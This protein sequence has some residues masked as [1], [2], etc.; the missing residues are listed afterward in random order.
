MIDFGGQ[1]R[2]RYDCRG[3]YCRHA[4]RDSDQVGEAVTLFA[5]LHGG[6]HRGSC[7]E[8][9]RAELGRRGHRTVAPDLPVESDAAGATEWSRV[10]VGA[11]DGIVGHADDDV[12]VVGH[13]IS[14]LCLPVLATMRPV[15]RLVFVGGLL[16]IPAT[17]FV[18]HLA[19]NRD[20][21]TFP[22]P[23]LG[24]TGPFGLTWKS[25]RDGFYHDCPEGLARRAFEE[26]RQQ[27][28]TVFLERCPIDSWPDTPS[29]YILMRDDRA[30]GAVWAR[31]NAADR[32][33]ADMIELSG[34]HSPFFARPHELAAALLIAAAV[35]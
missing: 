34:G 25:V 27:S 23:E 9:V 16:P 20:A 10:A 31:R 30:V 5:L 8:A 15:R 28:F 18:E 32:V 2:W 35:R 13:S 7:W 1:G 26:M 21:I 12:V 17:S 11:I 4:S 6:M 14:G 22:E 29:T 3:S 19:E 24:G 33:G